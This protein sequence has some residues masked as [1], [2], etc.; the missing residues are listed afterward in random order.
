M[1]HSL[2]REERATMTSGDVFSSF[3]TRLRDVREYHA[4][5][6][7][8]A[9]LVKRTIMS[10]VVARLEF[11]GEENNG[12][13]LDL[14]QAHEAYQNLPDVERYTCIPRGT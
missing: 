14:H 4:K 8:D 2:L 10:D 5:F 9:D 1:F 13:Y 3:Y 7:Q 11:S 12:R 6:A